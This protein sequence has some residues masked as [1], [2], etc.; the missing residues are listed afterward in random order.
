MEFFCYI[1]RSKV[2]QL[3]Q[4]YFPKESDEWNEQKTVEHD[5]GADIE[6]GLSFASILNLFKGGITYGRKG[7][8]QRERKVKTQ[9][10]EKLRKVL[11]ALAREQPIPSL[12]KSMSS[13]KVGTCYYHEGAFQI[14]KPIKVAKSDDIITIHT[15]VQSEHLSL[16]CSLRFFS[17][18]NEPDGTFLITSLTYHFFSGVLELQLSTVFVLLG[19]KEKEIIG[20]PLFLKLAEESLPLSH[21]NLSRDN[22]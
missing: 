1:S 22:D 2:D 7:V 4:I 9:Y 8:I 13:L 3:F 17:E 15:E 16:A 12:A 20:T 21:Q 18:G 6:A 19:L 10:T 5:V 11:L 14:S